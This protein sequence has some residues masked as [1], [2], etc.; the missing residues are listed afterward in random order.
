M[1]VKVGQLNNVTKIGFELQK[2]NVYD[3]Q[4]GTRFLTTK[5]MK[6]FYKNSVSHP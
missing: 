4:Q 2:W 5:E 6:K 1:A 3:E